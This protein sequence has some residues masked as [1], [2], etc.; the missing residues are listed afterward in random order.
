MWW[1]GA[2]P[3][4]ELVLLLPPRRAG[5]YRFRA[6]F[7]KAADYGIVQLYLAGKKVG[8]PLDLYHDGVV[9]SGIVDFGEVELPGGPVEL[10]VKIV[11]R[12][13]DSLAKYMFGLDYLLLEAK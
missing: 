3:G 2:M 1:R 5:K 12:N 6:A 4:D 11:G 13:R 7:T 10:T 9:P 8:G